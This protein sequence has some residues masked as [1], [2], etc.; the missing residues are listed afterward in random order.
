VTIDMDS[1]H[2]GLLSS[3]TPFA[4]SRGVKARVRDHPF[5]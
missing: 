4:P 5:M 1:D 2:K 3:R